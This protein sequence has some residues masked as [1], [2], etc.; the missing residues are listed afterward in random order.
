MVADEE[1]LVRAAKRRAFAVQA[2][3]DYRTGKV[4][5]GCPDIPRCQSLL[6]LQMACEKLCKSHLFAAHSAPSRTWETSHAYIRGVLPIVIRERLRK[7]RPQAPPREDFMRR[8]RMLA[9]EI[10]ILSPAIDENKCRKD[11]CEYPWESGDK[12]FTP[13]EFDFPI[14][15]LLRERGLTMLKAIHGAIEDEVKEAEI[16]QAALL[17]R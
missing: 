6:F 11:N 7:T 1:K 8:I 14:A 13:S 9:K 2:R 16:A 17:R 3:A 15:T 5:E 4:L 10:E 12:V